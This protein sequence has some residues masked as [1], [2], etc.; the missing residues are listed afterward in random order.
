MIH[1]KLLTQKSKV[2]ENEP[3]LATNQDGDTT[4]TPQLDTSY[5]SNANNGKI[6]NRKKVKV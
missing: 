2:L 3:T 4:P 6:F 5:A 1:S